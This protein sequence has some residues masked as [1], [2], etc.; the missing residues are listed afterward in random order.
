MHSVVVYRG[1]G[2]LYDRKPHS[3]RQKDSYTI[4]IDIW[5]GRGKGFLDTLGVDIELQHIHPREYLACSFVK[6][7]FNTI[8]FISNK[9]ITMG[10]SVDMNLFCLFGAVH[11]N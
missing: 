4:C 3:F 6:L 2:L 9:P 11:L 1:L 8:D 10:I 5:R 7:L